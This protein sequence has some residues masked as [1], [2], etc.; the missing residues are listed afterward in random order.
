MSAHRARPGQGKRLVAFYSGPQAVEAGWRE[1]PPLTAN[2]KTDMKTPAALAE[3][4]DGGDG[5]RRSGGSSC[6]AFDESAHQA[7]G[8]PTEERLAAA[9]AKVLGIPQDRI[10][11]RDHFFDR[12][13][14][15]LSTV[16]PA[17]ALNRA[18]S[19]KG[20]TRH[21]VPADQARLVDGRSERS[22]G[23][24]QPLIPLTP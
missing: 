12:G 9:W 6:S 23:L 14:T 24:L 21:R 3:E 7:P 17:I 2:S 4:L 18:V 1:S 16:K 19:L 8:T 11:R 22:R 10:D 15:S 20:V 13:G 5:G